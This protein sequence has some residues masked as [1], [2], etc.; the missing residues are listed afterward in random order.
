[1]IYIIKN[2]I[3]IY[4]FY[5]IAYILSRGSIFFSELNHQLIYFHVL[6]LQVDMTSQRSKVIQLYKNVN[7][8]IYNFV[9]NLTN[10]L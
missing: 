9:P 5:Y 8:Y 10:F 6:L 1:M 3:Y 4:N 7:I 2:N